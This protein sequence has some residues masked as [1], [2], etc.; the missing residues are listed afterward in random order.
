MKAKA[1]QQPEGRLHFYIHTDP[2]IKR[3]KDAPAASLKEFEE[4]LLENRIG[5]LF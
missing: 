2:D 4:F 3:R 5:S 1:Q